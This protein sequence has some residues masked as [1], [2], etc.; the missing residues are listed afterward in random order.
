[1][2]IQNY[3]KDQRDML[4]NCSLGKLPRPEGRG[5]PYGIVQE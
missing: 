2:A 1:M 4:L 3:T 5:F